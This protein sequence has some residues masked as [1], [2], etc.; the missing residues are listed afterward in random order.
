MFPYSNLCFPF[1]C[2]GSSSAYLV[3]L[4]YSSLLNSSSYYYLF[5]YLFGAVLGLCS[6]AQAF[7]SCVECGPLSS[8][9]IQAS[10]CSGCSYCR[11]WA[12]GARASVVVAQDLGC[13]VSCG[14]FRDQ[15]LNLCLLHCKANS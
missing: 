12:L 5:I 6:Y 4:P 9:G 10:H 3:L 8:C 1:F 14:I 11:S 15:E 13:S 2:F 7:S